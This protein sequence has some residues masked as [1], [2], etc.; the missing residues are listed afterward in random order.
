MGHQCGFECPSAA[1][2]LMWLHFNSGDKS[3]LEVWVSGVFP[4]KK[5]GQTKTRKHAPAKTFFSVTS[6]QIV[7][8]GKCEKASVYVSWSLGIYASRFLKMLSVCGWWEVGG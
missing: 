1:S 7:N 8:L 2:I 3:G 6:P 5:N 4:G